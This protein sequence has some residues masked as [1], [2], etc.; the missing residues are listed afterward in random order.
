MNIEG[1]V[2]DLI[3][4][5][6][7]A[8]PD[9]DAILAG[10]PTRRRARR[11]RR[12]GVAAAAAVAALAVAVPSL[13]VPRAI[14]GTATPPATSTPRPAP[15]GQ[16]LRWAAGW[17]PAGAQE[18]SRSVAMAPDLET[19]EWTYGR[20]P[21]ATLATAPRIILEI[22]S[23]RRNPTQQRQPV[24]VGTRPGWWLSGDDTGTLEIQLGPDRW[25]TVIA[26]NVLAAPGRE[27][28]LRVG[29]AL[30][31]ATDTSLAAPLRFTALPAGFAPT[32][33]TWVGGGSAAEWSAEIRAQEP[34]EQ[35]RDRIGA[36]R[37]HNT[38]DTGGKVERWDGPYQAVQVA[39]RPGRYYQLTQHNGW[40]NLVVLRTT[41]PG[42]NDA[43][44][45]FAYRDHTQT[46][47]SITRDEL[48]RVAAGIVALPASYDWL[49]G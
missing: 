22:M 12:L 18:V 8:A 24:R 25:A 2:R 5:S 39:G 47:P 13:V 43:L 23:S 44:V 27:T 37:L 6:A 28:E 1:L 41:L 14:G 3:T 34:S 38:D 45:V 19:R 11:R 46:R 16:P 9:A 20:S 29:A 33:G 35:R 48:V 40:T 10:L 4:E 26:T 30:R 32:G 15:G 21:G 17:L 42:S 36:M 31:P 49:G 7:A